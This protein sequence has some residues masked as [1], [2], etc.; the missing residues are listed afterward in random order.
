MRLE[1]VHLSFDPRGIAGLHGVDLKPL[2]GELLAV[3]GP[4]GAG[5]TTLLRLLR[6]DIAPQKGRVI[7]AER[8]A[9]LDNGENPPAAMLV[10]EWL[11]S[12]IKRAL[13]PEQKLQLTRDLADALEFTFQLKLPAG[14]LSSGLLQRVKIA[15]ALI[16]H[17]D[18]LLLDEPFAHLDAPTRA[19]ILAHLRP[20]LR[21]RQITAVWVTHHTEDALAWADRVAILHCGKWEH[22]G[23]PAE[24]FHRPRTLF[25]ARFLGHT[26][27]V[28]V[29]R[30]SPAQAWQTP[31]GPWDSQGV[32]SDKTR[33]VM[34]IPPHA[35][36]PDPHGPWLGEVTESRFRGH[37]SLLAVTCH[38]ASWE[39]EW[40]GPLPPLKELRFSV[41]L[42]QAIGVDCL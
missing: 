13:T 25:S 29:G 33:V 36:H 9:W 35:F 2:P 38:Q 4:N 18:L 3:M 11:S 17:P 42:G 41:D 10:G 31:F 24:V 8:P 7:S 27:L 6:G 40:R 21:E 14:Q 28:N 34:A 1:G 5:K 22:V 16:D 12:R 39:M 37:S 30:P 32:A 23:T 20:Y 19:D 15:G 26:N